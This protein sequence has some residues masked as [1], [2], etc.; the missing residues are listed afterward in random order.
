LAS[1]TL[2]F[3]LQLR[4]KHGKTSVRVTE[5][6]RVLRKIFWPKME[7]LTRNLLRMH[8]E[9]LRDLDSFKNTIRVTKLR[10]MGL[11]GHVAGM[12]KGRCIK[13]FGVESLTK[14]DT[15]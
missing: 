1:Y 10:R 4:K 14:E 5:H 15:Y 11:T 9:E 2:A 6:Y 12:G 3:A 7:E 13:G 8:I